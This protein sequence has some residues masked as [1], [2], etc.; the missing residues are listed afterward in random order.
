MFLDP[1]KLAEATPSEILDSAARGHLGLDRRFLEGLLSRP[2]EARAAALAFAA[3]DRSGDRVDL[4]PDLLALFR[5]WNTAEALPFIIQQIKEEPDEIPDEA[6]ELLVAAGDAALEPL[7][8]LYGQ[9]PEDQGGEVAFVLAS[10]P[11]RDARILKALTDRMQFDLADGAFL[12]G[13]YGDPEALPAL[14]QAA[15]QLTPEETELAKDIE[16]AREAILH[17]ARAETGLEPF[18]IQGCYPETADVPV[19]LLDE[20]ERTDLLRHPIEAVRAAAANSFFNRELSKAQRTSLLQLAQS[21]PSPKVR[22]RAWESLS[23]ETEDTEVVE[24][25]LSALRKPDL[26][27]EERGGL[28]VGLAA[29][30]DRNEVRAAINKLYESDAGRAKAMEAMWRSMHASFRDRFA[31]HLNDADLEVR[32]AALWGVGYYG[33]R[34][35][36]DKIREVFE[37]EELRSDALFAYTLALPGEVSRGRIKSMFTRIEKDARGLSPMEEELV[38]TA[39]DEKLMLAGKEPFF[40]PQED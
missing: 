40:A 21:D 4:T 19:D 18:D 20:D 5:Y 23:L 38:K 36:L 3:R 28:V 7:L 26:P 8:K 37:D 2:E 34:S 25:M 11:V 32:R 27:I 39:L 14:E 10:L 33:I 12:L 35:E 15:A 6:T 24:A 22:G 9:L 17:F 29:E 1:N 31:R 13:V 30:A 16:D